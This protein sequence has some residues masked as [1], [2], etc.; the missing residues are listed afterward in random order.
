[1]GPTPSRPLRL[2]RCQEAHGYGCYGIYDGVIG[3]VADLKAHPSIP[4]EQVRGLYD[5]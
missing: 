5:V 1:M 2:F 4:V 3:L